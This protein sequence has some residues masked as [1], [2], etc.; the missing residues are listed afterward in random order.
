MPR[1]SV[2][3]SPGCPPLRALTFDVLGL[4]KV[5]EVRGKQGTPTV[6]ER[7]GAPDSSQCVLAASIVD[8]KT[9]PLLAVARKNGLVEVLNPLNGDVLVATKVSE[10]GNAG[11]I[12]EDDLIVGLHLFKTERTEV[13]SRSSTF[14]SCTMKGNASLRSIE[15][16]DVSVDSAFSDS[17][18]TWSVCVAGKILCS[19]VDRSENYALFG[20]KGVEVNVWDVDKC[21]KIWAA[22]PPP[23]NSLDIFTPTWFTA[24]TF[25]NKED[26]RKIVAGTNNH[27]VRLYDI[28]AQRRPCLSFDFRTS[29]IKVVTEDLD[30]HTIYLGT[31]SGDLA[32]FDMRTGKLLGCF[33]GKCCGSI[34]SIARHPE[35]PLIASCGLDGY[36]RFWD[37]KTRQPLSAVFLKQHLTNVVFD[38]NFMDGEIA[39]CKADPPSEAKVN[40]T[41]D[42]DDDEP[43]LL[44]R[45]KPSKEQERSKKTKSKKSKKRIQVDDNDQPR[46]AQVVD[47]TEVDDNNDDDDEPLPL[48]RRK[49]SKEHKKII[50]IK[51][52][53]SK[54][55]IQDD[56]NDDTP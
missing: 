17:P 4:V 29:P 8:R 27:Q 28:S 50:R 1:T 36:L 3:E 14:L 15:I 35:L 40:H 32:S 23:R 10:A 53:L 2:V 45:R 24:A 47:H 52:K 20:G 37:V 9:N 25:L 26:H 43:L 6:V 21:S 51:S 33:I 54:K 56:E 38:S 41:A 18:T 34:R 42:E 19:S 5:V 55:R 30:G 31:G 49:A 48:K 13:K 11:H 39:G 46:E 44:E 12:P 7:W 22:K 16:G